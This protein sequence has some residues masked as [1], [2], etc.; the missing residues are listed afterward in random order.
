MRRRGE[1]D[2][3]FGTCSQVSNI[4]IAFQIQKGKKNGTSSTEFP[5]SHN[6]LLCL[7]MC[8]SVTVISEING[9]VHILTQDQRAV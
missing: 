4:R 8:N 2:Y 3:H 6:T 1:D 7:T 5:R 9:I